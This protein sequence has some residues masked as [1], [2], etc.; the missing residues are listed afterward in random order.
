[1]QAVE[2]G[3]VTVPCQGLTPL[4]GGVSAP[5]C[6][7]AALAPPC[8]PC[9]E[10]LCPQGS[11]MPM[12]VEAL[13]YCKTGSRNS[14]INTTPCT[15]SDMGPC[16][17]CYP[18]IPWHCYSCRAWPQGAAVGVLPNL[19]L[20]VVSPTLMCCAMLCHPELAAAPVVLHGCQ[21]WAPSTL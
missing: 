10:G 13:S 21:A 6:K 7:A 4:Q 2:H 14:W 19:I 12:G 9:W 3:G 11:C 18:K 8:W 15:L 20:P 5:G 16:L 17:T 1:M